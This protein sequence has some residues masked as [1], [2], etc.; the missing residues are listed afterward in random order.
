[1]YF[2]LTLERKKKVILFVRCRLRNAAQWFE[3]VF[4]FF[5]CV[6][7][8]ILCYTSFQLRERY[9]KSLFLACVCMGTYIAMPYFSKEDHHLHFSDY[10]F[11]KWTFSFIISNQKIFSLL[12][13]FRVR[14][15][16]CK[17]N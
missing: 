2:M 17:W 3:H 4:F 1:M 6:L 7:N 15:A 5:V 13:F 9:N 16:L 12:F 14:C 11:L 10:Y 8:K